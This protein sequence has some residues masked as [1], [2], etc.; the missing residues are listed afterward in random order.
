TANGQVDHSQVPT[1][2][3]RRRNVTRWVASAGLLRQQ[4]VVRPERPPGGGGKQLFEVL[5]LSTAGERQ[6]FTPGL[7]NTGVGMV[8]GWL[9]NGGVPAPNAVRTVSDARSRRV[10]KAPVNGPPD[11][12]VAVGFAGLIPQV[13]LVGRFQID[14]RSRRRILPMP[15]GRSGMNPAQRIGVVTMPTLVNDKVHPLLVAE[16]FPGPMHPSRVCRHRC[17]GSPIKGC[18]P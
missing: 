8:R 17:V 1:L 3:S 16:A 2:G 15:T 12:I 9:S 14:K 4:V 6:G 18:S 5:H 11:G 7:G 13:A 10:Q